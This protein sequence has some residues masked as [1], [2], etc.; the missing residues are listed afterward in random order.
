MMH[1]LGMPI[2]AG[3]TMALPGLANLRLDL[4][5]WALALVAARCV[6][7]LSHFG[8]RVVIFTD[9]LVLI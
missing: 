6:D 7:T 4:S 2:G 5:T 1:A 9:T 3:L 8:A